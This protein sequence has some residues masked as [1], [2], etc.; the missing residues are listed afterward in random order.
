MTNCPEL[1]NEN[2]PSATMMVQVNGQA[3]ELPQPCSVA[4]L[5]DQLQTG[6]VAVAVERNGEVVPKARHAETMLQDGDQ[7]EIVTLVG[8]G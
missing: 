2:Q 6:P 1:P 4:A 3:S 5:L 8:G 7:L